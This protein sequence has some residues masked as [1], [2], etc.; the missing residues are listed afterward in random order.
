MK[1]QLAALA[2]SLLLGCDALG[3]PVDVAIAGPNLGPLE[4]GAIRYICREFPFDPAILEVDAT[5]ERA[6][7]PFGAALRALIDPPVHGDLPKS[8]WHLRGSDADSAEFATGDVAEGLTAVSVEPWQGLL[9]ASGDGTCQPQLVSPQ[10]VG[11]ARWEPDPKTPLSEHTTSFVALVTERACASGRAAIGRVIRP[12]I[13]HLDDRVAIAFG[14]MPQPDGTVAT[15]PS[16]PSVG[17][18]VELGEE[19]GNRLL[20][21]PGMLPVREFKAAAN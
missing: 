19:L 21:D 9:R 14:V 20:V 3:E 2:A 6:S 7:T 16:N 5:D 10:P 1:L 17:I 12:T 13:A 15:C 18:R 11:I 4:P 8:G